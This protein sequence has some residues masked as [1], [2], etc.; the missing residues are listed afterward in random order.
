VI[1]AT[2]LADSRHPFRSAAPEHRVAQR[3]MY[4][5]W[6]GKLQLL[7]TNHNGPK[8][9]LERREFIKDVGEDRL[10]DRP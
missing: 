9:S 7:C 2:T 5:L 3:A 8:R 4:H 10:V 6:I 1:R